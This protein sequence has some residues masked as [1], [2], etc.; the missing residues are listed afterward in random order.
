[1][2]HP[3]AAYSGAAYSGAA[4]SGVAGLL[5]A[6]GTGSRLGRPKALVE[7]G[8]R[9]LAERGI[10]LLRDGGAEPVVLVTGAA[11]VNLPGVITVHNPDWRSGMGSSLRAG[12][13]TL[14]DDCEAAVV[15]LVD[16]PLIGSEAVRRLIAAFRGGASVAVA[17]YDG[18]PR[19][20]VLIAR[21]H[22]AAVAEAA[23]GDTGARPFLRANPGLVTPV[24]CGDTGRPDDVDTGED[25]LRIAGLIGGPA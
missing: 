25:L 12:L 17:C 5:L 22:W 14:P 4:Y 8:G 20:P 11:A 18:Q 3:G 13:A 6:A 7:V 19:N 2:E 24:E 23:R 16:Q 15:A 1:M 9:S 21:R 10:A